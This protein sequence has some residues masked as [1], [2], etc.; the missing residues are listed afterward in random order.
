MKLILIVAMALEVS[1]VVI[2]TPGDDL[3]KIDKR[4][5]PSKMYHSLDITSQIS[6][7]LF[8]FD[9]KEINGVIY[10]DVTVK[11]GVIIDE[12]YDGDSE[13]WRAKANRQL[14]KLMII[15]EKKSNTY[16]VL[17]KDKH[18][19]LAETYILVTRVLLSFDP[20]VDLDYPLPDY[21]P[22]SYE[23]RGKNLRTSE[24]QTEPQVRRPIKDT[25]APFQNKEYMSELLP[26]FV[27]RAKF[28]EMEEDDK[29]KD[30]SGT[31]TSGPK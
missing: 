22:D 3:K 21:Q 28:R 8:V 26:N 25:K 9:K 18:E 29:V 4:N 7:N 15:Q 12:I 6:R 14:M 10:N 27:T 16:I 13:I 2:C 17:T 30:N 19:R 1:R 23:E 24:A 11:P 20:F 31:Q 5:N